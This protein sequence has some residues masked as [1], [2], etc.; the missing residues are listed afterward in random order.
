M[1]KGKL[2]HFN[3]G[4]KISFHTFLQHYNI[5]QWQCVKRTCIYK[6]QCIN[7]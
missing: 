3:D 1:K 4:F 6:S 7:N 2:I 5:E